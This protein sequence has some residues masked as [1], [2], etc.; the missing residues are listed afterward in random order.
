MHP[1]FPSCT[2]LVGVQC[3]LVFLECGTYFW[4]AQAEGGYC[5]FIF[6]VLSELRIVDINQY[7]LY[8]MQ[9]SDVGK[10]Y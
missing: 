1:A 7:L 8:S 4:P 3:V 2:S 6:R 5:M 9:L 10:V